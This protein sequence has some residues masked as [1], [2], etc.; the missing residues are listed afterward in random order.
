M[1][2]LAALALAGL[3]L[4]LPYYVEVQRAD[5]R[6]ESAAT[7]PGRLRPAPGRE[8]VCAAAAQR[9][10]HPFRDLLASWNVDAPEAT[11]FVVELRVDATGEGDWSA[12]MHVGD[13]GASALV[14]PLGA[15]TTSCDGGRV[16]VDWFRGERAFAAAQLRVRAFAAEG[17]R[18][19]RVRHLTLCLS[20]GERA[21]A[22]LAPPSPRPW[23]TVLDVPPRSQK[24]E[25]PSIASRICSPTSVAM[26]LGRSGVHAATAD[27]AARAFDA[28]HDIYGNW[29]RNVQVAW[30]YGVP[31]YLARF[32]DWAAVERA[33]A[34][35]TPLVV[36]VAVKEGQLAGAPYAKS[37]GH[38][39]VLAG[40]D[41]EGRCV[42]DDPAAPDAASVRRTYR[43]EEM[44]TVW[45]ERGGTAYVIGRSP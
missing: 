44:E 9:G 11:G 18:E 5:L 42:V 40:F 21:V 23:G 12:W 15:R 26:V 43:R 32:A 20:D 24:A 14:P 17:G 35:G 28:A 36:S 27:V 6:A 8:A 38:L 41:A 33:I 19:L 13:W 31:G 10:A 29:P 7:E 39:L 1:G 34:D 3:A 4:D 45:L 37:S 25:D 22:A 16:D 2:H 30:T